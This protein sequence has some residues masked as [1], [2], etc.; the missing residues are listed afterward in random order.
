M[1]IY[2]YYFNAMYSRRSFLKKSVFGAA[3]LGVLTDASGALKLTDQHEA[4]RR[5][6]VIS[7]WDFGVAANQSAWAIL[8]AGGA[9]LDAVEQ[10]VR[11]AEADLENPTVGKG[12]ILI[13]TVT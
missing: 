3:S 12:G 8:S 11:V 10:G 13:E 7:T 6:I 1:I 9:A 4:G 2:T 5:P